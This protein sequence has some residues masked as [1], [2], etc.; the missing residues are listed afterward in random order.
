MRSRRAFAQARRCKLPAS[1][2]LPPGRCLILRGD[3]RT[4]GVCVCVLFV[5]YLAFFK[6]KEGR[7]R[8]IIRSTRVVGTSARVKFSCAILGSHPS[9][10]EV[11]PTFEDVP[12]ARF[13]LAV[14]MSRRF[15]PQCTAANR[16]RRVFTFIGH[17]AATLQMAAP[18][19]RV[20]I[21]V[22]IVGPHH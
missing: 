7:S 16:Q 21:D 11:R 12:L 14:F 5:G 20:Q 10:A 6:K 18:V 8:T 9:P 13:L 17:P 15:R 22:R 1:V 19:R 3:K 4:S 2:R